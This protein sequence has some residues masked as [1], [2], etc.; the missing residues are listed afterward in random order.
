MMQFFFKL[1][2]FDGLLLARK[3]IAVN[4]LSLQVSI[5]GMLSTFFVAT[6]TKDFK[7][8]G[9]IQSEK[10]SYWHFVFLSPLFRRGLLIFPASFFV[11]FIIFLASLV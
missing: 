1:K 2:I 8:V 4:T 5:P 6:S 11:C 3:K 10:N 9:I 7:W